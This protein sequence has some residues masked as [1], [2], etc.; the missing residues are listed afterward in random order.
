MLAEELHIHIRSVIAAPLQMNIPLEATLRLGT[1][2][3]AP[4]LARLQEEHIQY[5]FADLFSEEDDHV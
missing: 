1:I 3:P 5:K 2:H 4:L